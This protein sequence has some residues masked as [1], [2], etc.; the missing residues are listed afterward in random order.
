MLEQLAAYANSDEAK[1]RCLAL[2]PQT[3]VDEIR[4]LQEQTGAACRLI[5]L[6]GSPS[7]HELKEIAPSLERADRGGSLNR[8]SCCASRRCCA[9]SATPRPI[10]TATMPRPCSTSIFRS[11]RRTV[12][13]RR[14]SAPAS[15]PR[16]RS[17]TRQQELADIRRHMRL[18]S[19]K[20]KESLQ[21]SSPRRVMPSTCATRSSRCA[22]TATVAGQERI[23]ERNSRSGPR[24][25]LHGQ[26]VLHRADVPP[27]TPTTP[28]ASC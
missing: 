23:Q 19:A 26:H 21:R 25:L 5:D 9:A 22:A 8:R 1:A 14:R 7:F 15:S 27:S 2:E 11:F 28:C 24:R 3:D 16:M 18:Q 13:W 4:V 6:K 20:V 10:T 17:P 12:I